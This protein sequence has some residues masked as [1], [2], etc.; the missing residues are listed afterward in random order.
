LKTCFFTLTVVGK[1]LVGESDET[2]ISEYPLRAS[3]VSDCRM[4]LVQPGPALVVMGRRSRSTRWNL[5]CFGGRKRH[6]RKDGS[7]VHTEAV[8]ERLKPDI[9][10]R[11]KVTPF[12]ARAS[13]TSTAEHGK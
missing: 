7:C 9:R 3:P 5:I 13:N 1:R 11:T 4:L 10:K 6:Y 12:G 2:A 8:L